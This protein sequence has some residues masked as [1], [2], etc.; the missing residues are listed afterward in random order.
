MA[1]STESYR[2][3]CSA[4]TRRRVV[5]FWPASSSVVYP[6]RKRAAWPPPSPVTA[7]A[8]TPRKTASLRDGP[9]GSRG[10]GDSAQRRAYRRRPADPL[11]TRG[12][13][14]RAPPQKKM[15]DTKRRKARR[16]KAKREGRG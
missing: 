6:R 5:I 8:P 10:K 14:G 3:P 9:A 16:K 2:G 7:R 1:S 15:A 12:G 4:A 13:A 11:V